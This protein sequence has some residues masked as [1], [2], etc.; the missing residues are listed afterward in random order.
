MYVYIDKS[1]CFEFLCDELCE[2]QVKVYEYIYVGLILKFMKMKWM[3]YDK[4]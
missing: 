4:L 3:T 1:Y 2:I